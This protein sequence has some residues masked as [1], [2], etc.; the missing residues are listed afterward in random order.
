[1]GFPGGSAVRNPPAVQDSQETQFP[2]LGWKY[3]WEEGMATLETPIDR[4]AGQAAAVG[5]QRVRH[6]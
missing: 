5:L 1:M 3:P 6:S 2:S 4:G